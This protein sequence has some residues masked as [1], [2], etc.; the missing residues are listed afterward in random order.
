MVSSVLPRRGPWSFVVV[1]VVGALLC[2]GLLA[3]ASAPTAGAQ[4]SWTACANGLVSSPG[5]SVGYGTSGSVNVTRAW[6]TNS[7]VQFR[8]VLPGGADKATAC[9]SLT[10]SGGSTLSGC[11]GDSVTSGDPRVQLNAS[12]TSAVTISGAPSGSYF[13]LQRDAGGGDV[14]LNSFSA[15]GVGD[16]AT[17]TTSSTSTTTTT[18]STT[19][20]TTSTTTT[21]MVDP[22]EGPVRDVDDV[23]DL[24]SGGVAVGSFFLA[25]MFV[26]QVASA[27]KR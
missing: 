24:V 22:G 11:P 23:Y 18:T 14:T 20:S 17:T 7:T 19:T 5:C 4:S 26:V 13:E 2:V 16:P 10:R 15:N 1:I 9:A 12:S 8:V 6:G 3:M 27:V 25:L 21:T